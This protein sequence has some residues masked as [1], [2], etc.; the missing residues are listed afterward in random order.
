MDVEF[1]GFEFQTGFVRH[2]LKA[3]GAEIREAGFG[4]N[5]G[6]F[7][8]LNRDFVCGKLVRPR[9]DFRQSNVQPA[10]RML[11]RIS[12]L[13]LTCSLHLLRVF[14]GTVSSKY[15]SSRS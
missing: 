3:D 12:L 6:V 13:C 15:S 1:E 10:F 14:I 9:F 11:G 4:A 5:G 2:V 8:D 7:G